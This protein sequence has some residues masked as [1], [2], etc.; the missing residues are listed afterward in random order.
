MLYAALRLIR[1]PNLLLVLLT[2]YLV[3]AGLLMP[4]FSAHRIAPILDDVHFALFALDTLLV[5]AGGYLINDI[6]DFRIDLYNK[7]ERV[8][9]NRHIRIQTAYWLYF[10]LNLLGFFLAFYLALYVGNVALANLYP[11]AVALLFVYSTH[12]Q[13]LPLLGNLVIALFS[14]GVVGIV[15]F[16]E[17]AGFAELSRI[18]PDRAGQLAAIIVWYVVFALLSTLYRELIKDTEDMRGDL[19]G[20]YRTVPIAWGVR[21]AKGMAAA[22]GFSLAV[23]LLLMVYRERDLF[24][25]PVLFYGSI[26]LLV[27]LGLSLYWLFSA[28]SKQDYHRLSQLAKFIMLCGLLLLLLLIIL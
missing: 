5:S 6:I 12:L 7:P 17:R 23:F 19:G 8:I 15:W 25:E 4:A 21:A 28:E 14:A 26:G 24:D 16:A 27:P 1:F 3:Y 10:V 9:I 2:Q 22:F 20:R 13:R 18:A 11:L